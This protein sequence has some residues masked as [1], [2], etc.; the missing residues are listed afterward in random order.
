MNK[1]PDEFGV[2]S[3]MITLDFPDHMYSSKG[4][5]YSTKSSC[6]VDICMVEEIKYLWSQGIVTT[7]CCCG[8]GIV[9]SSVCTTR[10][11][12]P[13][14]HRLGY[15]IQDYTIPSFYA[16]TKHKGEEL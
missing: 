16:K 2:Y 15:T 1:C 10:A 7:N 13:D 6:D 5:F 8:H 3:A 4:G 11:S 12:I 14:M 9:P